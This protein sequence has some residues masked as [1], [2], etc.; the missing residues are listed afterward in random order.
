[1]SK[2]I[3]SKRHLTLISGGAENF[4]KGTREKKDHVSEQLSLFD[5][6]TNSI[7]FSLEKNILRGQEFI[8]VVDKYNPK[9][10][11]DLRIAPRLDFVASSRVNAFK[12]FRDLDISYFDIFGSVGVNSYD[13]IHAAPEFWGGVIVECL[14]SVRSKNLNCIFLFDNADIL[15]R[16]QFVVPSILKNAFVDHEFIFDK[17][18]NSDDSLIAM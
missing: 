7:V 18:E 17:V 13:V 8:K 15:N 1:M 2:H 16:S 12:V 14:L 11:F 6:Y 10:F 9:V 5:D 3:F 4:S